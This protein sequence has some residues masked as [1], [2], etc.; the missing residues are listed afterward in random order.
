MTYL[1]DTII[2]CCA[3]FNFVD[4]QEIANMLD[5]SATTV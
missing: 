4:I 5:F 3:L 2:F 1:S